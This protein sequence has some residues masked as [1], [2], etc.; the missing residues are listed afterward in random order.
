MRRIYALILAA[1]LA[2]ALLTA[3]LLAGCADGKLATDGFRRGMTVEETE[4]L[5]GL[6][7]T[8]ITPVHQS[9]LVDAEYL[10][11]YAEEV[12]LPDS[13]L[14]AGEM[15]FIFLYEGLAE[16][17][18][19]A[20]EDVP[21]LYAVRAAFPDEEATA[22]YRAYLTERYGEPSTYPAGAEG[23]IEMSF[24]RY[25]KDDPAIYFMYTPAAGTIYEQ[26]FEQDDCGFF[27]IQYD[28]RQED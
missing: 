19:P 28:D 1:M 15:Q 23:D 21:G 20:E 2:A 8:D 4:K 22:A 18:S 17:A 14:T 3:A 24:W 6:T 25:P 5:L 10:R 13:G 12:A 16:G 11:V 9:G 7:F 27:E 26:V